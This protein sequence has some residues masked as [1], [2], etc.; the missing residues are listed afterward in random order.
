VTDLF[1]R[2]GPYHGLRLLSFARQLGWRSARARVSGCVRVRF[3]GELRTHWDTIPGRD[4]GA[5]CG[6]TPGCDTGTRHH[7]LTLRVDKNFVDLRGTSKPAQLDTGV[8]EFLKRTRSLR[9]G[10]SD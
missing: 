1:V 10:G 6:A 2:H 5:R 9:M 7:F 4:T 8:P 3:V